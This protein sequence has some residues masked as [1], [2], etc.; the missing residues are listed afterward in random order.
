MA[1]LVFSSGEEELDRRELVG[2]VVIG[3][4]PECT[5]S[6]RDINLSR[7]HCRVA[8][9]A[10]GWRIEDLQSKNGTH[11]DGQRITSH[12]LCDGQTIRIGKTNV[13]FHVGLFV[14]VPKRLGNRN[15]PTEPQ[16]DALAGTVAGFVLEDV[17]ELKQGQIRFPR[18]Q[19]RP[20]EPAAYQ[21]DEVQS[22][23]SQ[24]VS[25]SWDSI[26]ES[27]SK[28][29][30]PAHLLPRPI[31]R[32]I[33]QSAVRKNKRPEFPSLLQAHPADAGGQ[34][35]P[36]LPPAIESGPQTSLRRQQTPQPV[37]SHWWL[38]RIT[39]GLV[40]GFSTV[41][42]TVPLRGPRTLGQSGTE[43]LRRAA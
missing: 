31:I 1:Y 21:R 29:L 13:R 22:L 30:K 19:P 33:P 24:L 2:E 8:S 27:A 20:T 6:V 5:I 39:R 43:T 28:P 42:E 26:Y 18:P 12:E 15:R 7:R 16:A 23:V 4:S 36:V 41:L 9:V 25:S 35:Q 11:L 38:G 32:S 10:N 34:I 17:A 37:Q 14:P 3:R 40:G